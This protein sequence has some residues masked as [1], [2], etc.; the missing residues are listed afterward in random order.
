MFTPLFPNQDPADRTT[1]SNNRGTIK[2]ILS[3]KIKC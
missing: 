2:N 3:E 1:E